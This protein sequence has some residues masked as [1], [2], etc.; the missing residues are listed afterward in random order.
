MSVYLL[1]QTMLPV[2][3]LGIRSLSPLVINTA[4]VYKILSDLQERK[5]SGHPY[6]CATPMCRKRCRRFIKLLLTQ[7]TYPPT[8]ELH[9]LLRLFSRIKLKT[10]ITLNIYTLHDLLTDR[11]IQHGFGQCR[12][13]ETQL[14]LLIEDLA[15]ALELHRR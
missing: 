7:Y 12:R 9:I 6:S 2:E 4:G 11:G 8:C 10:C 13:C 3:D 5:A 14:A 1:I 15:S